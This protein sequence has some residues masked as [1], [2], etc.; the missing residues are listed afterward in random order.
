MEIPPEQVRTDLQPWESGN[1]RLANLACSRSWIEDTRKP[2]RRFTVTEQEIRLL[3]PSTRTCPVFHTRADRGGSFLQTL[4]AANDGELFET[5]TGPGLI[6]LYEATMHHF[7]HCYATYEGATQANINGGTLLQP[8]ERQKQDP[9]FT[10]WPRYWVPIEAVEERLGSW[11]RQW[12]FGFRD[13]AS[14]VVERTAILS[15]VPRAGVGHTAPV[16]LFD[17]AA[18]PHE[19][20]CLLASLDSSGFDYVAR[21]KSGGTHLTYFV[22]E[23]LPV[24][25]PALYAEEQS[26]FI[27]PRALR[28]ACTAWDIQPFLDDVWREASSR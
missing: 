17:E 22:L 25:S 28:L 14:N 19:T 7:D 15:L 5:E 9:C 13:V 18:H 20:V 12:L 4:D 23:Q 1:H 24:L 11:P 26:A 27:V 2:E 10:V 3:N 21:R 8:S 6:P 16:V